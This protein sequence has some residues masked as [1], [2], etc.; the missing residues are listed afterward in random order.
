MGIRRGRMPRWFSVKNLEKYQ[1]YRDRC[2]AWIKL[3][4]SLLNDY[5]FCRLDD[6]SRY[7][8]IGIW[9][10]ASRNRNR[11]PF[12]ARWIRNQLAANSNVNLDKLAQG[13][14]LNVFNETTPNSASNMLAEPE[15][16]AS[17][18]KRREEKRER[19]E[20]T[21]TTDSAVVVGDFSSIEALRGIGV[22]DATATAVASTYPPER[23]L[24]AVEHARETATRSPSGMFLR[25]IENPNLGQSKAEREREAEE[26]EREQTD[27]RAA[28]AL[29]VR[30]AEECEAEESARWARET[31]PSLSE[32]ERAEID[33]DL[34]AN[35]F[36]SKITDPAARML[37]RE[38]LWRKKND[39]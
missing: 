38:A 23:I 11:L 26:R 25:L 5:E 15:H 28:H 4:F 31:W 21:T 36:T 33:H 34:E 39:R 24:R 7:H 32:S 22:D 35:P 30:E 3:Y 13:G 10:L 6:A 12:D 20:E 14:F 16:L 8:L 37:A 29:R 19:R 17:L 27:L 2:P 18:E 9:L 1:H